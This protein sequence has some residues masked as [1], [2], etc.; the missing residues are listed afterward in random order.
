MLNE[1]MLF[2]DL[3]YLE[4]NK[5]YENNGISMKLPIRKHNHPL[6]LLG[7]SWASSS[8]SSGEAIRPLSSL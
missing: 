3:L 8:L 5:Q 6:T 7:R 4:N 1:M 2:E